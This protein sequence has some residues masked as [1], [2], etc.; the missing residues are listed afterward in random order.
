MSLKHRMTFEEMIP[1]ESQRLAVRAG[2]ARDRVGESLVSNVLKLRQFRAGELGE[3]PRDDLCSCDLLQLSYPGLASD[4]RNLARC[5]VTAILR[6]ECRD[7]S[8]DF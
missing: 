8:F 1:G 6:S 4:E 2:S 7:A 5:G 3:L